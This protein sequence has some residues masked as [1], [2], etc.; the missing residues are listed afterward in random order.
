MSLLDLDEGNT[1]ELHLGSH[2]FKQDARRQ[3]AA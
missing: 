2:A 1:V 3:M